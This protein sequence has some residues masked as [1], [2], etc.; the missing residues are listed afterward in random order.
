MRSFRLLFFGLL[1]LAMVASVI[2]MW[3]RGGP[4]GGGEAWLVPIGIL[5][6]V[7]AAA[8]VIDVLV[9]AWRGRGQAC[10]VCGHV[11]P[12]RSFRFEGPCP[13]CGE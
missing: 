4:N 1:F 5:G 11:R 3:W 2:V 7:Y 8:V 13:Q 9:H 10:R 12:L 6:G